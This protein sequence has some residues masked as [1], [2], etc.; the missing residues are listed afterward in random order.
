MTGRL[1]LTI[2]LVLDQPVARPELLDIRVRNS[3]PTMFTWIVVVLP[4]PGLMP[5]VG[6]GDLD[7]RHTGPPRLVAPVDTP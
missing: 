3:S 6:A 1:R 7:V 5:A 4:D 2:W